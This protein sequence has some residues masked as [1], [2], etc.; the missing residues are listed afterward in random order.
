[1]STS[2]Y[3]PGKKLIFRRYYVHPKTGEKIYPKN[4]KAFPLWVDANEA[5]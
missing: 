4:G 3:K 1:M 5:K 2:K